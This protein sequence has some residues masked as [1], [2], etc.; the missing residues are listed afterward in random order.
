MVSYPSTLPG[1]PGN[2]SI[3]RTRAVRGRERLAWL[4]CDELMEGQIP[5]CRAAEMMRIETSS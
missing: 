3:H 4:G 1:F 2:D 5:Q